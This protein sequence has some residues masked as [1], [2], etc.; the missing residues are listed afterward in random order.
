MIKVV[1]NSKNGIYS[2]NMELVDSFAD[3]SSKNLDF[4][5]P[6]TIELMDDEE[7]AKNPLGTTAHYNP[8]EMKITIYVTGRHIKDILRSISHELI[9]HVQNCRGDL[10]GMQDTSLGYAQRDSHMRDMETEAFNC[11][12][13]M[14]FR[15]FEDIYKQRKHKMS[16]LQENRLKRLNGLLMNHN[17]VLS[18]QDAVA[19]AASPVGRFITR[20][21][22]FLESALQDQRAKRYANAI[23]IYRGLLDEIEQSQFK[24]DE[25]VKMLAGDVKKRL[26]TVMRI[27]DKGPQVS[28]V[29]SKATKKQVVNFYRNLNKAIGLAREFGEISKTTDD[30]KVQ[31][32]GKMF[33]PQFFKID[34]NRRDLEPFAMNLEKMSDLR[35]QDLNTKIL[36][37]LL[38]DIK[39]SLD[40]INS[41]Q[42]ELN[43]RNR[44]LANR[45]VEG[46]DA[47]Q[48]IIQDELTRRLRMIRQ[49]IKKVGL[50]IGGERAK[51]ELVA[52]GAT[53]KAGVGRATGRATGRGPRRYRK[54]TKILRRGC[55]GD[56]V[57][58]LQRKL[59]NVL[60][61]KSNVDSFADK[62][63]G[64]AT[65]RA[66][67]AFQKAA[68]LKVDG[69]AG[70]ATLKALDA[71][72]AGKL[73]IATP[74]G[75][76]ADL[77]REKLGMEVDNIFKQVVTDYPLVPQ[78][79]RDPEYRRVRRQVMDNIRTELGSDKRKE[80]LTGDKISRLKMAQKVRLF[81][82]QA[83]RG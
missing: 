45:D 24:N 13:I 47:V 36:P 72:V 23:N 46:D 22:N 69:V 53:G 48:D 73:G 14:I 34:T 35:K 18:E 31:Q 28:N 79:E 15:D 7:N 77:N 4:D 21:N 19:A 33:Y 55:A 32:I 57:E 78:N 27:A 3:Y 42:S 25:R 38:S 65:K 56:N 81:I 74:K 30:K 51:K 10:S 54:C 76:G 17:I 6:V 64:P 62:K 26:D 16:K 71:A 43:S 59:H 68:K 66:V 49:L 44:Y 11:G 52:K 5:K 67:K 8:D 82:S 39:G 70:P 1:D 58:L 12:N 41:T 20:I 75:P 63:F 2:S 29:V 40:L 60:K 83:Q 50:G 37:S 61:M 80:Y 9:H